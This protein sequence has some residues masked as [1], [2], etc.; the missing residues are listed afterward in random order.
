MTSAKQAGKEDIS[1]QIEKRFPVQFANSKRQQGQ[2]E[3]A[4]SPASGINFTPEGNLILADS[5]R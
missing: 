4:L 2:K 1:A 3:N 5:I